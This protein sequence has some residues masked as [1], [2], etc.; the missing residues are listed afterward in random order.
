MAFFLNE[1]EEGSRTGRGGRGLKINVAN[2]PE[3][4]LNTAFSKDENWLGQIFPEAE[5]LS[6]RLGRVD[7]TISLKRLRQTLYL[8]GELRSTAEMDCSRCLEMAPL[9]I[10]ATFKYV[11]TP[12]PAQYQEETELTKEDL[13]F[14]HYQDDLIDLD[15]LITEQIMLQIPMKVLCREDC[16][17]LCPHC[18]TNLNQNRCQCHTE[19]VDSR[20]EILKQFK[21]REID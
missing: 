20:F 18:G 21:K 1:L 7:V 17:G 15:P 9:P 4:G 14:V 12:A 11:L 3:E 6:F 2:I 8:E 13:D 19:R 10:R 5:R 16:K